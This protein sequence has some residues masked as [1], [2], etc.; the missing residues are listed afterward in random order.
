MEIFN[1]TT[2]KN[3]ESVVLSA[4][5]HIKF[6][7]YEKYTVICPK[8]DVQNFKLRLSK[9][10]NIKIIDENSIL[11]FSKFSEIC[12]IEA[13]A[14]NNKN[15]N[16]NRLN[17]YYQQA[18][19]IAYAIECDSEFL[20]MWDADSIPL[21][22]IAFF[23]GDRSLS[24]GSLIEYHNNYFK[25]ISEIFSFSR[26]DMAFTIQFFTLTQIERKNLINI[27]LRYR[28]KNEGETVAEWVASIIMS[29]VA[30]KNENIDRFDQSY[31]SEQ[32]LVGLINAEL[33]KS[34]QKGIMHFRPG[35]FWKLTRL[36]LIILEALGYRYITLERNTFPSGKCAEIFYF[37]TFLGFDI[38]RNL[39]KQCLKNNKYI[40]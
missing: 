14:N 13:Q 6:H 33:N 20:V 10:D 1:V 19:K 21:S 28:G 4:E 5:S 26:P 18:L 9:L 2:I 25:T 11:S 35:R 37:W 24:Y 38:Y 34:S 12:S 39:S 29:S 30:A 8:K 32:E 36:R 7:A 27:L 31:F 17:W 40:L 15:F 16:P 22:K 23:D 3:M